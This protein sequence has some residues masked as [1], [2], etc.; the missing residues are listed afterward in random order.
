MA[1][2]SV[3]LVL[4]DDI[5]IARGDLIADPAEP[6]AR[7]ARARRDAGLARP[8]AAAPG[9]PLPGAAGARAASWPRCRP[10]APLA[11]E[12]HRRRRAST[13]NAPLF[14]DSYDV[15]ARHRV[16]DPDRRGDQPDGR[17]GAGASEPAP[18]ISSAP[19]R[20][21]LTSSRCARPG[22]SA[23]RTS[24][25]T[26][27][28]SRR[29]FSHLLQ[30]EEESL[31][32]SAAAGIPPRST[33]STSGCSTRRSAPD[34]GAPQRRRPDAVRPRARG[35]RVSGWQRQSQ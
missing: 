7:D 9:R 13:L 23:R 19:G 26:T 14:V 2:D 24:F 32:A 31:S 20:A 6:A 27:R 22:C 4:A 3:T 18:S 21:H 28:W 11:L 34:R 12:R 1:G 15:G 8:R 25:S 29:K 10:S 33:S 5:D 16:A 35:N 30:G 17:R